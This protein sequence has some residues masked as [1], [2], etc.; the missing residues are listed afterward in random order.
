MDSNIES[1]YY[2][3][4]S[5]GSKDFKHLAMKKLA[6]IASSATQILDMGCGEGT[7]LG[8][9]KS[10]AEKYG[11]DINKFAITNARKKY[12]NIKF[13]IGNLE[14]LPYK[15]NF[16][17]LVYSA[18]VFEHLD[19]PKKVIAEGLRVLKK[20]GH[21][22]IIAPNFGA[23]NRASPPSKE[24]RLTKLIHGF[25][26]DFLLTRELNWQKVTPISTIDKYDID[27]DTTIEPYIKSLME[28]LKRKHMKI[29]Y[30]SSC[31]Q[32]ET[33]ENGIF[34]KVFRVLG[35]IGFYPFNLWGP[36][37]IVVAQK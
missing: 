35:E 17:D 21:L 13:E 30:Y 24:N 27:W 25:V 31:W 37:L 10:K 33:S 18:Y 12:K 26:F 7:R 9:L 20:N 23:P 2:N 16:F 4:A 5:K 32:E 11:I 15:D 29:D 28:F 14:N 36:H 1:Y 6:E 19:N 3:I 34:Q 22:I 8:L